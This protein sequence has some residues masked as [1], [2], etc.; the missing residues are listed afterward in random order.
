MSKVFF[1]FKRIAYAVTHHNDDVAVTQCLFCYAW[2]HLF[3][4]A[5]WQRPGRHDFYLVHI[6]YKSTR[7]PDF[8]KVTQ[9]TLQINHGYIHRSKGFVLRQGEQSVYA[10]Q[11]RFV[12]K[13]RFIKIFY[14]R[15]C[16]AGGFFCI[17]ATAHAVAQTKQK[18]VVIYTQKT[19]RI[20][21]YFAVLLFCGTKT[22]SHVKLWRWH[23]CQNS[24]RFALFCLALGKHHFCTAH[25]GYYFANALFFA[26]FCV[27][28]YGCRATCFFLTDD[29]FFYK[30]AIPGKS[31]KQQTFFLSVK[32]RLA[33]CILRQVL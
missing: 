12:V 17:F 10:G 16:I 24:P 26:V 13:T 6:F 25:T 29:N 30:H 3:K 8:Y 27:C 7:C 20:A 11:Y 14:K 33:F 21:G 15:N 9:P 4:H 1:C 19:V 22:K 23:K 5:K 32:N 2:R 18:S 31:L 28:H